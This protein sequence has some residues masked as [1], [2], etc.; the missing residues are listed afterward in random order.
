MPDS[1]LADIASNLWEPVTELEWV[2]V[3]EL[4]ELEGANACRYGIQE[5]ADMVERLMNA[6]EDLM[7]QLAP[8]LKG[9]Q[10]ASTQV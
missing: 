10:T 2:D 6:Y 5:L 4:L 1:F 8:R 9:E 3:A 7:V